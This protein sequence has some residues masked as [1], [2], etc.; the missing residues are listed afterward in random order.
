MDNEEQ[1]QEQTQNTIRHLVLS[2][3]GVTGLSFYGILRETSERN[4]W[5][6]EN[7][8]TIYGT[9]I[10][11]MLAAA[12]AL[13][14]DW[15]DLE[16]YLVNRPWHN[17]FKFDMYSIIG[18]IQSRGIFGIQIVEEIFKPLFLGK[19]VPI[20]INMADFY[21]L[22]KIDIHIFT[23]DLNSFKT[24][25]ISHKTHPEWKVVDAVYAS[26]SLPIIFSPLC[27]DDIFYCDGGFFS[28]YPLMQCI[29][30]GASPN[31]IFGCYKLGINE[32]TPDLNGDSTLLDY[33][34]ILLNKTIKNI[35]HSKAKPENLGILEYNVPA[36]ASSIYS[37]FNAA[38]NI[39]ERI[40]LVQI[41]KDI[42]TGAQIID[43]A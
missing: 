1:E 23:T 29:E 31:E 14:Y 4:I 17:V 26:S 7:I 6:I 8:Q 28:N 40:K 12:L 5:N 15:A 36:T 27:K 33:V 9:S 24:V 13:K 20:D 11:A 34:M 41:G 32:E 25:D 42:V 22:T 38:S 35:I 30:N 39:E 10:G 18:S 43:S 3:G 2:G 19:D 16:N 21:E 37:I